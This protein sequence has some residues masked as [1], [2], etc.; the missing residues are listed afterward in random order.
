[1]HV[2]LETRTSG[3]RGRASCLMS[4]A[5]R[6]GDKKVSGFLCSRLHFSSSLA[7]SSACVS[8]SQRQFKNTYVGFVLM[9]LASL[10]VPYA[11]W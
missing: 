8:R 2:G 7:G 3:F 6:G 4:P 10:Y 11:C 5:K 9:L 1:M